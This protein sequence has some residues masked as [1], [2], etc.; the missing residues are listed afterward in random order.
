MFVVVSKVVEGVFKS[1]ASEDAADARAAASQAEIDLKWKMYQ[2][3]REDL[4][5]GRKSWAFALNQ[6]RK[7][8]TD[9]NAYKRSPGDD[10]R[11]D[12]GTENLMSNAAAA[13]GLQSGNTLKAITAYGQKFATDDY[14][15]ALSRYFTLAG[16]GPTNTANLGAQYAEQASKGLENYGDARATGYMSQGNIWGDV[17]GSAGNALNDYYDEQNEPPSYYPEDDPYEQA[18][19]TV[20]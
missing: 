10:W 18:W 19:A 12:Q 4:A 17:I 13:G 15:N 3:N 8:L 7:L 6:L 2:Q 20:Q 5:P 11:L 14:N 9:P 1:D 16:L